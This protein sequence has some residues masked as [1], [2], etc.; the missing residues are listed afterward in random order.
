MTPDSVISITQQTLLI[1]LWTVAPV[2]LTV[3]TIGLIWALFQAVTQLQD[4]SSSF[5]I[6][7]VVAI[8]VMGVG[9]SWMGGQ[10]ERF[11]D[12]VFTQMQAVRR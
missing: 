9:A 11:G 6:K 3:A 4:N 5:A 7:L 2:V 8:V 10:I 12:K 1:V